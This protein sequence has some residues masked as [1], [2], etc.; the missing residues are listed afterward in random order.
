MLADNADTSI[1]SGAFDADLHKP[2][3]FFYELLDF[4]AALLPCW[5]DDPSRPK[6]TSETPLTSQLC[7]FLNKSSRS[8]KGWDILHFQVEKQ[9]E[10]Y[11]NR[12]IDL[13][14]EHYEP[15]IYVDGRRYIEYDTL[16]PI[17]CKLLPTPKGIDRDEREYVF[18]KY[19][20]AGGIHRFKMGYHGLK[21][22]TAAMIGYV[23]EETIASWEKRI[24]E[25]INDLISAHNPD[26]IDQ[27][28]LRH[29]RTDTAL[30]L[31]LYD[32]VHIRKS[33]STNIHLRHIWIEMNRNSK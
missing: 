5:R 14:A 6:V 12:S 23:Q 26:W 3:T 27:D 1:Q 25:W 13:V 17:E 33:A 29:L 20:S 8:A 9:D 28:H 30:G 10:T 19:H 2:A 15:V 11:K 24:A 21:H 31:G 32:S 16:L 4:I 7:H 22:T 18:S